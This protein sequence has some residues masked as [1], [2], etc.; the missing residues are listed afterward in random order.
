MNKPW[1]R[2]NTQDWITQLEHRLEDINYYLNCAV[3]W[4]EERGITDDRSVMICGFITCIWV[5]HMRNEPISYREMLE[6]LGL[7]HL[8]EGLDQIYNL[9]PMLSKLDHEQ[10]LQLL[11]GRLQDF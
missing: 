11:V 4:C 9:G 8:D 1:L 7:T 2:E 10:V 5:S 6:F 3:A